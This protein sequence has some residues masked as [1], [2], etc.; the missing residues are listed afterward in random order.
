MG[1]LKTTKT[2]PSDVPNTH[3]YVGPIHLYIYFIYMRRS[4]V[5]VSVS[6]YG[7][8]DQALRGYEKP[9]SDFSTSTILTPLNKKK[10]NKR[11][12]EKMF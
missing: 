6:Y 5:F 10:Q 8:A 11:V 12:N 9:T 3:A 2:D 7:R 4:K 1:K